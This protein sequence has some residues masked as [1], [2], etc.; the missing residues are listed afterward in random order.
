[1]RAR[2]LAQRRFGRVMGIGMLV[3]SLIHAPLPQPDFHTI[4]HHDGPGEVCE[5]HDHLLR[6]HPNAGVSSDVAVL[7]W[8]W[9]LPAAAGTDTSAPSSGHALH[10]HSPDWEALTWDN[11]PKLV[12]D[13]T[14]ARLIVKLAASTAPLGHLPAI[15]GPATASLPDGAR[16]PL[17]FGA[18][19]APRTKLNALFQRWVC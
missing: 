18:S 12:A 19:F 8:H 4:R 17:S 3:L 1:M 6:W 2:R 16:P 7:H 13:S 10:A 5:K 15:V 11:G 9:F 14:S